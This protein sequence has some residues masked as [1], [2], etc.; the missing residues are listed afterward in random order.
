MPGVSFT[1]MRGMQAEDHLGR[2]PP[3]RLAPAGTWPVGLTAGWLSAGPQGWLT[4]LGV[5][6][7]AR[8]R[9]GAVRRGTLR[10]GHAP[11]GGSRIWW[12]RGQGVR[13]LLL[14][15]RQEGEQVLWRDR[16]GIR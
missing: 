2:L 8:S 12:P 7:R 6:V 10:P 4:R 14:F 1:V 11:R 3:G 16:P 5:S 9:A 15:S 13:G